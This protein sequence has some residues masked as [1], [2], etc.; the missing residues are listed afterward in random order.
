[1]T[2]PLK[3]SIKSFERDELLNTALTIDIRLSVTTVRS[4]ITVRF[5]LNRPVYL[6]SPESLVYGRC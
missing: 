4:E 1:M 6:Q 3:N 5:K 2:W